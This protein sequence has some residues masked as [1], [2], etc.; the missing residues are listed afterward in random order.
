[1]NYLPTII[2]ERKDKQYVAPKLGIDIPYWKKYFSYNDDFYVKITGAIE[3]YVNTR[4]TKYFNPTT[5]DSYEIYDGQGYYLINADAS[6]VYEI[7][8]IVAVD[9]WIKTVEDMPVSAS[10]TYYIAKHYESGITDPPEF[11]ISS[12][13]YGQLV[14]TGTINFTLLNGVGTSSATDSYGVPPAGEG[15]II[16]YAFGSGGT[17][18]TNSIGKHC[19]INQTAGAAGYRGEHIIVDWNSSSGKM[20]ICPPIP[21]DSWGFAHNVTVITN[22]YISDNLKYYKYIEGEEIYAYIYLANNVSDSAYDADAGYEYF[23]GVIEKIKIDDNLGFNISAKISETMINKDNFGNLIGDSDKDFVD[24]ELQNIGICKPFL[25]G[26]GEKYDQIDGVTHEVVTD[27]KNNMAKLIYLGVR[28]DDP[29]SDYYNNDST[30]K[31]VYMLSE[32]SVDETTIANNI[33]YKN[34]DGRYCKIDSSNVIVESDANDE[35]VLIL[36]DSVFK[37]TDYW[38][39][40]GTDNRSSFQGAT[41]TTP[42]D[43]SIDNDSSVY[44]RMSCPGNFTPPSSLQYDMTFDEYNNSFNEVISNDIYALFK[45]SY[46]S[47]DHESDGGIVINEVYTYRES[48]GFGTPIYRQFG[49]DALTRAGI[50]GNV[51]IAGMGTPSGSAQCYIDLYLLHKKL[52]LT[53]D[54]AGVNRDNLYPGKDIEIFANCSGNIY[55]SWINDRDI[56]DANPNGGYYLHAH[57]DSN[58]SGDVIEN[59]VGIIESILRNETWGYG[60]SNSEIDIDNFN[61]VSS[62]RSSWKHYFNIL[63]QEN[64]SQFLEDYCFSSGIALYESNNKISLFA[65]DNGLPFSQS[66]CGFNGSTSIVITDDPVGNLFLDASNNFEIEVDFAPTLGSD[67]AVLG[68]VIDNNNLIGI[69]S[70]GKPYAVLN[71]VAV[72]APIGSPSYYTTNRKKYIITFDGTYITFSDGTSTVPSD[73]A[74]GENIT[75]SCIG[76]S[77]TDFIHDRL[78]FNGDIYSIKIWD[79]GDRDTGTLVLNFVAKNGAYG[80]SSNNYNLEGV[81]ITLTKPHP[82]VVYNYNASIENEKFDD[83]PII[84]NSIIIENMND[85][86]IN[87]IL[88][89]YHRN[90]DTLNFQAHNEYQDTTLPLE[91]QKEYELKR[92]SDLTT[93]G[94]LKDIIFM[95]RAHGAIICK[96]KTNIAGLHTELFDIINIRNYYLMGMFSNSHLKKWLVIGK[97]YN[98]AEM[99]LTITAVELL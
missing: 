97:K 8:E 98:I 27:Y 92:I 54:M 11:E 70:A 3:G 40:T 72:S 83:M 80:D 57:A 64:T 81:D 13:Q 61:R 41:I 59:P 23:S 89:H 88:F 66:I 55:G 17:N 44:T 95:A 93:V 53:I 69:T 29:S 84:K 71:G 5:W 48:S 31:A 34:E 24:G 22:K 39:P 79:G 50:N 1:M 52:V 90:N 19:I 99:T 4:F 36:I 32:N 16:T 85:E 51:D 75:L 10:V 28:R 73:D 25:F 77:S 67:M 82:Q 37:V 68:S 78:T 30:Y 87:N 21:S 58:G 26:V 74:S 43:N 60:L 49:S 42:W 96:F 65:Y 45:I 35:N 33:Y 76:A 7:V 9:D 56:G 20:K 94:L 63:E 12:K 86:I 14:R 2:S 18:S 38:L 46:S 15:Y 6:E 62:L 91:V 47:G